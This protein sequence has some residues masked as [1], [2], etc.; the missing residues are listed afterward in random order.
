MDWLLLNQVPTRADSMPDARSW[1]MQDCLLQGLWIQVLRNM[2]LPDVW[3][4]SDFMKWIN[5]HD[6][7]VFQKKE[8]PGCFRRKK[9]RQ[10]I[11][12]LLDKTEFQMLS[13]IYWIVRR[14][15]WIDNFMPKHMQP[16]L[17]HVPSLR[18]VEMGPAREEI[19]GLSLRRLPGRNLSSALPYIT[20][21]STLSL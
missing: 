13:P 12:K 11:L 16:V 8:Q 18:G 9:C 15:L 2:Y 14:Y 4:L 10:P 1:G 3:C 7:T 20:S 6:S 21:L 17:T 19:W 5:L